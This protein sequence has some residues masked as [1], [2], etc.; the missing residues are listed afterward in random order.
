MERDMKSTLTAWILIAVTW[1]LTKHDPGCSPASG[2]TTITFIPEARA[3]VFYLINWTSRGSSYTLCISW[4]PF[5]PITIR[6][7]NSSENTLI[8]RNRQNLFRPVLLHSGIRIF[9]WTI[10]SGL[11]KY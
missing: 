5:L 3:Q 9:S 11:R 1:L 8:K 6:K 10:E 7:K 4:E 2:T